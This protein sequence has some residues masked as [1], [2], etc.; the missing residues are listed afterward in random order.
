MKNSGE[1][2]WKQKY[3]F[4]QGIAETIDWMREHIGRYKADIYNL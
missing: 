4:E 2:D 1:T 3:T